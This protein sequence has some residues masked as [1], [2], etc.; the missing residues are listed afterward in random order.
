[1][2]RKLNQDILRYL[3][4][5]TSFVTSDKIA[6]DLDVSK[7]TVVR[8]ITEIN[9][10]YGTPIITSERGRGYKLNSQVYLKQSTNTGDTSSEERCNEIIKELLFV[11]PKRLRTIEVYE[12]FYVSEAAISK[13]KII[14]SQKLEKWN[15]SFVRS[16]RHISVIGSER[17]IRAAIMDIVLNLNQ[18]T[19]ISVLEDYCNGINN[20][21]DF[22]FTIKQI[23]Y[24]STALGANILYPYNISLFAHIYV[25]LERI[26]KYR[27]VAKQEESL[28]LLK[29]NKY[30]SPEIYSICKRI[31][32]NISNHIGFSPD[33]SEVIY[34]FEY[35]SSARIS[36]VVPVDRDVSLSSQIAKSY[37]EKI[38][39]ATN[40]KFSSKLRTELENHIHYMIQRLMNRVFLPNALLNEIQSGYYKLHRFICDASKEISLEY[41]LPEIS[42]DESGFICLYFAKIIELERRQLNAYIVCTTGIGTSELITIKISQTF[43]EINIVGVTSNTAISK[44]VDFSDIKVDLII[45]TIPIQQ[46]IGVPVVLVS[47]ILTNRDIE[48]ISNIAGEMLY[49]K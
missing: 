7:I 42:E 10:N 39:L 37:I 46:M 26:R 43:P 3:N 44:I 27:Y 4:Q 40:R 12:K 35:L 17:D 1:M 36:D 20:S 21:Q 5:Q 49:G 48:T 25:L 47:S 29:E 6:V 2:K 8:H 38:S 16:S 14:I 28:T 31:I 32:E 33:E 18:M 34:L 45:T 22:Y 24:A 23:E 19:D 15:L 13:D 41:S 11:A 9:S 30:F